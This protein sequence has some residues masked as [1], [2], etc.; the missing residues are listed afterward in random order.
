M[1]LGP[2]E[3]QLGETVERL[4]QKV[5][6]RRFILK[7]AS[8]RM[9]APVGLQHGERRRWSRETTG[10]GHSALGGANDEIASGPRAGLGAATPRPGR[11]LVFNE[12]SGNREF[13]S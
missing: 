11:A 5:A 12:D 7:P 6:S 2:S 13:D 9:D 8:R 4:D 1:K 3:G 10:I